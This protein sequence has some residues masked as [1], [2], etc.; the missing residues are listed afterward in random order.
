MGVVV[1]SN[2]TEYVRYAYMFYSQ[3]M[4]NNNLPWTKA[5]GIT[6]ISLEDIAYD[7]NQTLRFFN[8]NPMSIDFS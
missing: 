6:K 8:F 2:Q 3:N 5:K 4:G 1:F 7:V